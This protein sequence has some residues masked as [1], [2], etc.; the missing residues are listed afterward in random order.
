M[1]SRKI[2][3]LVIALAMTFTGLISASA[4]TVY[5]QLDTALRTAD[6]GYSRAYTPIESSPATPQSNAVPAM[7]ATVILVMPTEPDAENLFDLFIEMSEEDSYAVEGLENLGDEAAL[8]TDPTS[9]IADTIVVV[10]SEN[11]VVV[12]ISGENAGDSDTLQNIIS[13]ILETG[14]SDEEYAVDEN[15]MVTGGW[16]E[17]F[18]E[19]DDVE[20]LED[21]TPSPVI[22][23]GDP[24]T[25]EVATPVVA[26]PAVVTLPKN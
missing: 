24:S 15:G 10:R 17:A 20:G 4:E 3:S 19:P 9:T 1:T 23:F 22:F 26:T 2:A 8:I 14:P 21:F 11:T 5:E 16:S 6:E 12:G 25:L 13:H 18:P 7:I